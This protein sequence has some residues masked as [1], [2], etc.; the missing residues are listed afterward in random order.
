MQR[1]RIALNRIHALTHRFFCATT[2]N[3]KERFVPPFSGRIRMRLFEGIM[4]Y[5]SSF[6]QPIS[7]SQCKQVVNAA[8]QSTNPFAM[9][10]YGVDL[11]R[12][13][14]EEARFMFDHIMTKVGRWS[15]EPLC[16]C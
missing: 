7:R 6:C 8:N 15:S 11:F 10:M 16:V 13:Y 9:L 2:T 4:K 3:P 5:E 14:L 1:A 12:F